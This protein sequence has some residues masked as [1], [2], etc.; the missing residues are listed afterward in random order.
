MNRGAGTKMLDL[1]LMFEDVKKTYCK[2]KT[3][4][5]ITVHLPE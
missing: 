3:H 5:G 2:Y 1:R 4:S